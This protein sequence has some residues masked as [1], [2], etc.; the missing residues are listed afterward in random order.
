MNNPLFIGLDLGGSYIKIGHGS[1]GRGLLSFESIPYKADGRS[2]LLSLLKRSIEKIT[3]SQAGTETI[4]AIGLGTPGIV[5]TQSGYIIDNCPNIKEWIGANPKSFLEKEL[6]IPVFIRNDADLMALGES[7]VNNLSENSVLGITIGTGIGS[8]FV[9]NGNI[10]QGK[11]SSMELGHCIV[12]QDGID[13]PCGKKGCV[14]MYSSVKAI[15]SKVKEVTGS[16]LSLD[17]VLKLYRNQCNEIVQI[18]KDSYNKLGLIIANSILVMGA[19]II[20]IG[21][22][23]TESQYFDISHIR[24]AVNS[25]LNDYYRQKSMILPAAL[26]NKAAVWGGIVV[27][28][29]SLMR[30]S[31]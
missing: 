12:E 11:Y 30:L 10:Y 22:G 23:I 7:H 15:I 3:E 27:A 24:E 28:E 9:L 20:I 29:N 8:G 14:E 5:D 31:S 19:E 13:C 6:N 17:D 26:K 25:F 16:A 18:V 2:S 4:K 1:I 21:G